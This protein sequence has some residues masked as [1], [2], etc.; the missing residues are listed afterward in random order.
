MWANAFLTDIGFDLAEY[1]EQQTKTDDQ[2]KEEYV[3]KL[4]I[5]IMR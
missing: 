4:S 5:P 1:T 3:V 2:I